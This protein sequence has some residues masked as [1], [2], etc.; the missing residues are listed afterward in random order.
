M[1]FR[2]TVLHAVL[3]NELVLAATFLLLSVCT[4]QASIRLGG[5]HCHNTSPFMFSTCSS[6]NSI[7]YY[8]PWMYSCYLSGTKIAG[9]KYGNLGNL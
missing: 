2:L 3:N 6:W 4:E 9:G 7:L 1:A 5:T 8:V